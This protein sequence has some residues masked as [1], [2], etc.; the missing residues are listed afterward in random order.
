MVAARGG[1]RRPFRLA[2]LAGAVVAALALAPAADASYLL[3]RNASRVTLKVGTDGMALVTFRQAG[4]W[5]RVLVWGA[6]NA[7]PPRRG[8]P[9][10][11]FRV[12][13]TGGQARFGKPLW[14]TFRDRSRPYDGPALPWLVIAK[15]APNGSY[16]AL[17]RWPRMRPNYGVRPWLPYQRARELRLSHWTG[18]P[19]KLEV[20]QDW[21]YNG[22]FRHLFGLLSYRGKPVYGFGSTPNGSPTDPYGRNIYV[23]TMNSAYGRGW[24]RENSF[25]AHRPLGNF[26][27]GF[28]PHR[29]PA[30]YPNA[31]A[32]RPAG[33][34]TRVRA[35]VPG[36]GVTPDVRWAAPGLPAYD[37]SNPDHVRHEREMNALQKAQIASNPNDKCGHP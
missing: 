1:I 15:K 35:T 31:G 32:R 21:V 23:D 7:R 14:R 3:A 17:Q 5:H 18:A 29:L 12:D 33:H 11:R 4:R 19:A 6:V 36:P 8:V 28:F 22:R 13:R 9:Q 27:Y 16:W 10:V 30:H 20:W 25:L 34:G 24:K 37:A 2:A 26:C